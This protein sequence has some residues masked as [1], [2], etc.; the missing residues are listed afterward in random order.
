MRRG[1]APGVSSAPRMSVVLT[2][3]S[4]P[5]AGVRMRFTGKDAITLGRSK[6]T[7]F[8]V[9]DGTMSRV[10]AVVAR[11][12]HGW[13]LEDQRS[14]NG[15]WIGERQVER[16]PLASGTVFF[17]GKDT[18]IRFD[19]E[20]E[21]NLLSSSANFV[22][23]PPCAACGKEIADAA[24]VVRS[25]DGRPYHMACRNLD[26]LIGTDLGEFRVVERA[27]AA[28]DAFFFRA[29]Q[30]TLNRSVL[31]EVFDHPLTSRPGFR[32]ALLDEVRRASR[33]VHPNLLQIYAFDEARGTSFV[34]MEYFKGERLTEVLEKRRFVKIRG[35]VQV[36]AGIAEALRYAMS[37]GVMPA[38]ISTE[39]VLVSE[40]HE[41]KVKL[42]EEPHL[43]GRRP[44]S[45]REAPYVA[46]EVVA[47]GLQGGEV[48]SLVYSVGAILY[49]MLAGIPPYEGSSADAVFRR[50][51]RES[52][53]AL[54]RIN[55]KVS[56]ALARVVDE[57]LE[58]DPVMRPA[59]FEDFLDR[60]R[61]AAKQ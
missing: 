14:R 50:A 53:P 60:L 15:T 23:A 17:L 41:V 46:P 35:A 48:A 32:Q 1:G 47:S 8:H 55:L 61:Q 52:P 16:E 42:F 26:H 49:H 36:S 24:D 39:P 27:P 21:P 9:L 44:P 33:F 22:V 34:V 56:P 7:D 59:S 38:W 57:C 25:P 29:H 12:D 40:D 51:Q 5:R 54:R 43:E 31:L 45:A 28:G 6:T 18:S 30:P 19:V 2:V 3:I 20:D 4:G 37:E 10:H 11:D 13:Y 58:R